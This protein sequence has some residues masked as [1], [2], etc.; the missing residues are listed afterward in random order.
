MRL[1]KANMPSHHDGGLS[2]TFHLATNAGTPAF[3]LPFRDIDLPFEWFVRSPSLLVKI[4]ENLTAE[5]I[6]NLVATRQG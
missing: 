3:L 2:A 6:C 4:Y 1:R 5:I